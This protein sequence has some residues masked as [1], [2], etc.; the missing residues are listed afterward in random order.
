MADV[1]DEFAATK[2][3]TKP[4]APTSSGP[5][6]PAAADV[7]TKSAAAAA[8]LPA[9]NLASPV[10]SAEEEEFAKLMQ[11]GMADLLGG[12][13]TSP[14][15]QKQF[16]QMMRELDNVAASDGPEAEALRQAAGITKEDAAA[17]AASSAAKPGSDAARADSSFQETIKRTMERMQESGEAAGAA[18]ASSSKS[19]EDFMA[20]LLRELETGGGGGDGSDDDF[21]KMLMGIMEQL[22]NK[23]ILYEPMKEMNDKFPDWMEKNKGKHS[24]EDM[25]R[26]AEQQTLASEIVAKFEEPDYSDD[27]VEYRQYIVDRMQRV[28][29]DYNHL[30]TS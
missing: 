30:C 25:K 23:D 28:G 8:P 12:L 3:D 24:D 11:A 4:T 5:G 13:E 21:S 26:Y 9:P 7:E 6:R 1:L 17:A 27:K 15:M 29:L 18:A 22:T 19:D 2:L 16:E 20:K 10:S 14:D